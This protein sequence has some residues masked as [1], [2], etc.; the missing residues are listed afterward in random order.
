MKS[1]LPLAAALKTS[2]AMSASRTSA[3]SNITENARADQQQ[4]VAESKY[5]SALSQQRFLIISA[6]LPCPDDAGH[7][8]RVKQFIE[9]SRSAGVEI[10]LLHFAAELPHNWATHEGLEKDAAK[11]VDELITYYPSRHLWAPPKNGYQHYLDEWIEDDFLTF[12]SKLT[13]ARHFDVVVI[14]NVWMSKIFD[15]VRPGTVKVTETHDVFFKRRDEFEAIG[16]APEFFVCSEK[17]EIFGWNRADI[18]IGITNED[19]LTIKK[20]STESEAVYLPYLE[21]FNTHGKDDYLHGDKVTFGFMGSAHGFNI[22]ALNALIDELTTAAQWSPIELV[23]AGNVARDLTPERRALVKNLGYVDTVDDF[24]SAVDIVVS[25]LDNG[26]GLKIK[27]VEAVARGIPIIVTSHSAMGSSLVRGLVVKDVKELADRMRQIGLFRPP[28]KELTT[29][30]RLSQKLLAQ[31]MEIEST[32]FVEAISK[33]QVFVVIALSQLKFA[34]Q[35]PKFWLAMSMVR[36][37]GYRYQVFL[38]IPDMDQEPNWLQKLPAN[39]RLLG[40]KRNSGDSRPRIDPRMLAQGKSKVVYI[41]DKVDAEWP[42]RFVSIVDCRFEEQR[43][44]LSAQFDYVLDAIGIHATKDAWTR[45]VQIWSDSMKWDPAVNIARATAHLP[46]RHVLVSKTGCDEASIAM[47]RSVNG[48]PHEKLVTM[49]A[50]TE[51]SQFNVIGEISKL[52]VKAIYAFSEQNELITLKKFAKL[53][54]IKL[55]TYSKST[56]QQQSED[57]FATSVPWLQAIHDLIEHASH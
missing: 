31:R 41:T 4:D 29:A 55:V 42:E 23:I 57:S 6:F 56:G 40:S 8:K 49:T 53:N 7:R 50:E 54:G 27:V 36:E 46:S 12:V 25:P 33:R 10:V 17:D 1:R 34:P 45:S 15:V 21:E 28:L 30:V 52:N 48:V 18:N 14:N 13:S 2:D 11:L 37:L 39:V 35:N 20:R 43:A 38:D 51:L 22:H 19:C 47:V 44:P 24:Y 3:M 32:R 9:F 26:T 5:F 16:S